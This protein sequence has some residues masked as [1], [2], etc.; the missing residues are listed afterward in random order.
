MIP[1]AAFNGTSGR[2]H[3]LKIFIDFWDVID[4]VRSLSDRFTVDIDWERFITAIIH[5][6]Y[7]DHSTTISDSLAGCWIFVVMA[8][9]DE[10]SMAFALQTLRECGTVAGVFFEFVYLPDDQ[11][12][13]AAGTAAV[14]VGLAVEMIKQ[15]ALGQHDHLAL[16]SDRPGFLPLFRYLRDQGQRVV[17]IAT[18][19]PDDE[20]RANSWRQVELR[21]W[22][23]ALCTIDHDKTVAL[24]GRRTADTEEELRTAL[25]DPAAELEILDLSDPAAVTD[26]DLMFLILNR[27][28]SLQNSETGEQYYSFSASPDLAPDLRRGLAEGRIVGNLPYVMRRGRTV[29]HGDGAGGW[30]RG[31]VNGM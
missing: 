6:S 4:A 1:Y 26:K 16:V 21:I 20:L 12:I 18:G 10:P 8:P 11:T 5:H 13:D 27:D 15:A 3:R 22:L 19:A 30:V 9:Y 29:M 31:P 7:Q 25:N 14:G 23:R 24:V 2:D 17:H 28:L